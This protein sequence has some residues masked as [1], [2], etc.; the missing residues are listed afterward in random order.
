MDRKGAQRLA[1]S[2]KNVRC[3]MIKDAGHQ[4]IFDNPSEVVSK[5]LRPDRNDK[6][7]M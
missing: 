5:I 7:E 1:Y 3:E 2:N 4:L 6:I